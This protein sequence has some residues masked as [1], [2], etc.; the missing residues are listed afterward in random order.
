MSKNIYKN[1][2]VT[3][4]YQIFKK[5]EV[6]Y[7]MSEKIRGEKEIDWGD[8]IKFS[9]EQLEKV[10]DATRNLLDVIFK[11]SVNT[12]SYGDKIDVEAFKTVMSRL[13]IQSIEV[14]TGT[15]NEF[16][17]TIDKEQLQRGGINLEDFDM[18]KRYKKLF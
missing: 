1:F 17:F 12:V 16:L 18:W 3:L 13:A 6:K 14:I 5:S 8:I 15:I 9:E 2:K 4:D 7:K 10:Y 11:T